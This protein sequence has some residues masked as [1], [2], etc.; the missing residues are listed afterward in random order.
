MADRQEK[1]RRNDEYDTYESYAFAPVDVPPPKEEEEEVKRVN[2]IS[3]APSDLKKKA[4]ETS[5]LTAK[6]ADMKSRELAT[7]ERLGNEIRNVE[8]LRKEVV[9][10]ENLK[11]EIAD[12]ETLKKDLNEARAKIRELQKQVHSESGQAKAELMMLKQTLREMQ[13]KEKE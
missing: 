3:P 9:N 7:A 1:K 6:I 13:Q 4:N 8:E 2:A 11:K 10:V 12:V 5:A